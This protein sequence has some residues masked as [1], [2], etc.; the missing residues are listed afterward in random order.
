M[1]R[2]KSWVLA[3]LLACG[4]CPALSHAAVIEASVEPDASGAYVADG[5]LGQSL[6]FTFFSGSYAHL[7]AWLNT[8][9]AI[10]TEGTFT[11][12]QTQVL[13]TRLVGSLVYL[14]ASSNNVAAV[15]FTPESGSLV[16]VKPG[17]VFDGVEVLMRTVLPVPEP[18]TYLLLLAGAGLMGWLMRRRRMATRQGLHAWY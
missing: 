1:L 3:V 18:A 2:I 11:N 4:I 12:Y 14:Q 15:V 16:S 7:L 9:V 5:T 17:F 10:S 6:V 13:P 8:D